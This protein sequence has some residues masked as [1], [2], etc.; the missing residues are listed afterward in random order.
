VPE[1][2]DHL[3]PAVAAGV[4]LTTLQ[5]AFEQVVRL[6]FTIVLARFVVPADFGLMSMAFVV[7]YL[8][9]LVS[10]L[11]VGT[12]LVQ[13][14]ELRP[15]HVTT[16]FTLST[17]FGVV[18]GLVVA[19]ASRPISAYFH[20]PRLA[21]VLVA[22]SITF[23]CKGLQGAPRDMLRR[24]LRFVAYT[25]TAAIALVLGVLVGVVAGVLGLGVWALVLYS[26]VESVVAM[27]LSLG[28]AIR[29]G[30]WRPAIGIDRDAARDLAGFAG[31]MVGG[32]TLSY[33]QSTADNVV[34]GRILGASALGFYGLAYRT[35]LVP[36]QKVADVV[37]SVSVPAFALMQDDGPRLRA[38]FLR[39]QQA[40]AVVSF[41]LSFGVV[42]VSPLAVPLLLGPQWHPAVPTVQVLALNGPRLVLGRLC[43]SLFQALGHPAWDLA[44]LSLTV[45]LSVVA[46]VVGAR[47]GIV[48][49]AVGLTI[50]GTAGFVV[51]VHLLA[52]ALRTSVRH[53]L[54]DLAGVGAATGA[55]VIAAASA[56]AL[57]PDAAGDVVELV[58]A[59]LAGA[60]AYLAGLTLLAPGTLRGV[61]RDVLRRPGA[62]VPDLVAVGR[63]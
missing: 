38:A 42:V 52:R 25:A 15:A 56:R 18:L 23:V 63:S 59:T 32:R 39:A 10:D 34:V 29:A 4:R 41:P 1:P 17:A 14:R 60:G 45:P 61:A 55:L 48:G 5:Q 30:V 40:A 54:G 22:V 12:A 19:L 58:A 9:I 46:F 21:A 16:A 50:V 62:A 20:E 51:Q 8:A 47:H 33:V 7:T 53:V 27:V 11:G 49:V 26:V 31:F 57:V 43:S 37:T 44:L 3:G 36:V 28:A 24:E 2:I 13:R 6:G 35:M